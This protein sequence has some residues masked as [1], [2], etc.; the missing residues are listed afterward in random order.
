[1]PLSEERGRIA[2]GFEDPRQCWSV[3]RKSLFTSP[4]NRSVNTE[5]AWISACQQAR[6]C[7]RAGSIDVVPLKPDPCS[8]EPIQVWRANLRTM[9]AHVVPAKVVRYQH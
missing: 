4:G 6:S 2:L 9:I 7:G 5:P 3:S 1:M 8:G